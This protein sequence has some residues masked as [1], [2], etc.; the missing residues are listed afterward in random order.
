[1][2]GNDQIISLPPSGMPKFE[3]PS[4]RKM[5]VQI[6]FPVART[7]TIVFM[8]PDGWVVSS[9]PPVKEVTDHYGTYSVSFHGN[10][11]NVDVIRS[12]VLNTGYY[13]IEEYKE[14]FGFIRTIKNI[15]NSSRIVLS[16]RPQV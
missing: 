13:K 14:F 7:D 10:G 15:E 16:K 2:Y 3:D 4:F 11:K 9:L 6:D 5:P 8:V 1:V 12:F